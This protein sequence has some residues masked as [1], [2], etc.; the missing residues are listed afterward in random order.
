VRAAPAAPV[1]RH[2][3]PGSGGASRLRCGGA[4]RR[5]ARVI[6]PAGERRPTRP[7]GGPGCTVRGVRIALV[8]PYSWTYPGGVTRHIEAL[9]G[10]LRRLGHEA[11]ILAPFDPDDALARAL[12]RGAAPQRCSPPEGFVSLGRTFGIQM[13]GAVSNVAYGPATIH[14]LRAELRRGGYDVI[15]IHEPV[16]PLVSWDAL[17]C[18]EGVARVGTFHSFSENVLTNGIGN[19]LGARRRMNRLHR[20]IAV[21]QA[22]AWTARRFF[23]GEYRIVP[24]G[25]HVAR[26]AADA[27]ERPTADAAPA[28]RDV[29]GEGSR[30]ASIEPLRVLFIGQAV[31]R[32]GVP[33]LLSAFEALREQV[34]ATLTLVGALPQEVAPLLLEEHGVR[35]LGRVG[36]HE[37]VR[38]L[39]RAD[40]LCAPSLHGESFGMVLTEGFAAGLPVV[41]SDIPGYRDV[42]RDGRDGV[43][44][45]PG[46][47]LALADALRAMALDGARRARMAQAA[48][49]RAERFAWR[50]VAAEVLDCYEE[51]I[52]V[53]PPRRRA[54]RVAVRYG[55]LRADRPRVGRSGRAP[56][57]GL[58]P[59]DP[60]LKSPRR[61]RRRLRRAALAATSLGA[62]ALGGS[63]LAGVGVGRVEASLASSKPGLLLIGFGLMCASMAARGLAW[64]S[65]L[66]AAPTWRRPRLPETLRAAFVG[67]L[68]S[69]TLPARL[70]EPSRALLLSRRLGR[71]REML[72]VVLGTLVSQMLLNLAAVIGLGVAAGLGAGR[73]LGHDRTLVALA[74]V[75]VLGLLALALAPV[76]VPGRDAARSSVAGA[77]ALWSNVRAALGR[78]RAGLRVFRSGRLA[79]A[80]GALQLSAWG[81]QLLAC[82]LVLDAFGLASRVDMAGA[83]AVLFAV[84]VTA[85]L[86]ATPANVGVFQA[87]AVAA[88]AGVYNVSAP[89]AIAYAIALQAIELLAA[90]A[91]GLPALAREGI[92]WRELR[93]R[94]MHANPVRLEPLAAPVARAPSEVARAT[95]PL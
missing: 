69:A 86:P 92:S 43:L 74:L 71:P 51:A 63:E 84:N 36:E 20:R 91:M 23:G 70:G 35:A 31:A 65:I 37:K 34:P 30:R 17:C 88:L 27:P 66:R 73:V 64:H 15:H 89:V 32:K 11:R 12:H 83:A 33:V 78:T 58:T 67:V 72:P 82:W 13:N 44:V 93:L 77:A 3:G 39:A 8:S 49:A 38:E 7:D 21:S 22:A 95:A 40:V 41:A 25:V 18:L 79:T 53:A 76:V 26:Q 55:L 87:A 4:S 75:P 42:V 54:A 68:M 57:S 9:A 1:P 80:A 56:L 59:R 48:T 5:R 50:R 45:P 6:R 85:L 81:L 29:H 16:A 10:E 90:L 46:D 52:A 2:A 62:L 28:A 61:P 47:P 60:S 14:A 19:L 94:T 24:N